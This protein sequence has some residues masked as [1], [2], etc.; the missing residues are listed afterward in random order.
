M[1]TRTELTITENSEV[2]PIILKPGQLP[3][4]LQSLK[5]YGHPVGFTGPIEAGVLPE[6]LE[7]LDLFNIDRP[8][9][10][11][12]WPSPC[13]L[14]SLTLTVT[15]FGDGITK[16]SLPQSL[17][18]L[19]LHINCPSPTSIDRLLTPLTSLNTFILH[20]KWD[21]PDDTLSLRSLSRSLID[22]HLDETDF[23]RP[24]FEGDL[25]P[26]LRFLSL[27]GVN[28][29]SDDVSFN[30][31]LTC[32]SF[33]SCS[34]LEILDMKSC[35]NYSHPIDLNELPPTLKVLRLPPDVTL[36][37]QIP[38]GLCIE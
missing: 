27:G 34:E 15:D 3:S 5:L 14:T 17:R 11:I 18:Y 20:C 35:L 33:S 10:P 32:E 31:P 36:T 37:C 9:E 21:N 6:S 25:P 12:A 26:S 8:I 23:D 7:S 16:Y 4:S 38:E 19:S 22:L 13:N 30:Q 24:L 28:E 1:P 29:A 2:G